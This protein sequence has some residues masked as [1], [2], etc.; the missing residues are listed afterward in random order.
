MIPRRAIVSTA[1]RAIDVVSCGD[2]AASPRCRRPRTRAGDDG[3]R[4][5]AGALE[6]TPESFPSPPKA[7]L[8]RANRAV[9]DAGGLFVGVPLQVAKHNGRAERLREAIEFLVELGP[10][11]RG[12]L[13]NRFGNP[14]PR[15]PAPLQVAPPGRLATGP[16]ATPRATP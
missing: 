6:T 14:D 7:T 16:S 4:R 3:G 15:P 8:E 1:A 12:R 11:L 5:E 13:G 10:G 2:R 9:E